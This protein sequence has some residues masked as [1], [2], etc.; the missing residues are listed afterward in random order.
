MGGWPVVVTIFGWLAILGGLARMLFPM[1]LAEIAVGVI[2]APGV[3]P[4]AAIM[5]LLLGA[6][7]SFKAYRSG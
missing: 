4:G 3:L 1:Q 6:F 2:Q 5:Q 7:F